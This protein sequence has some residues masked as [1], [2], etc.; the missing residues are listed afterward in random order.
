MSVIDEHPTAQRVRLWG[1]LALVATA[2]TA[3]YVVN[4]PFWTWLLGGV[5]GLDLASRLGSGVQFFFFDTVKI[6]LLLTGIIFLVTVLRSYMSVERTRALLG[7]SVRGWATSW[8][9]GWAW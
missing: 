3:L 7:E 5:A 8:R 4:E 1:G 9:P 6:L 2:W